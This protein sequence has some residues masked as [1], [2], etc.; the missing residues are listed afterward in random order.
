MQLVDF[1]GVYVDNIINHETRISIMN[2]ESKNP[3]IDEQLTLLLVQTEELFKQCLPANR[4]Q[5]MLLLQAKSNLMEM[6]AIQL[7]KNRPLE[8]AMTSSEIKATVKERLNNPEWKPNIPKRS[9]IHRPRSMH[10]ELLAALPIEERLRVM[11]LE[12]NI[13]P[14]K[15]E[16]I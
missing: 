6:V 15:L 9:Q 14:K 5:Q 1:P 8:L 16:R 12:K 13:K 7:R 10:D 11:Q 3:P 2:M 4:R